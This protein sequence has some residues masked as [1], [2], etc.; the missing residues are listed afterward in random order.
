MRYQIALSDV[1][2]S[3]HFTQRMSERQID[4]GVLAALL[5]DAY[6][7]HCGDGRLLL[8]H[9]DSN[10]AVIF[11]PGG[12]A[13]PGTLVTVY[14]ITDTTRPLRERP[15]HRKGQCRNRLR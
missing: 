1:V 15:R 13:W 5:D 14:R 7:T 2:R 11:A 6:V 12:N 3:P 8:T 10:L 9:P 4:P